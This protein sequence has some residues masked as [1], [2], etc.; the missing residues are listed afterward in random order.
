MSCSV[1]QSLLSFTV[2]L[3]T[4]FRNTA[5]NSNRLLGKMSS[6]TTIYDF[7]V[8]DADG[9]DVSLEKYRF[10]GALICFLFRNFNRQKLLWLQYFNLHLWNRSLTSGHFIIIIII[11]HNRS[12]YI[13]LCVLWNY[14]LTA[15]VRG[16]WGS[17]VKNQMLIFVEWN[18]WI[19]FH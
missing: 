14:I 12:C 19:S 8:K 11:L 15:F 17:I 10:V 6:A 3:F 2:S 7:T 13:G 16:L 5:S 18:R 1:V 9:K 4:V